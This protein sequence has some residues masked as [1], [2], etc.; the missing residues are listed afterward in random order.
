MRGTTTIWRALAQARRDRLSESGEAAPISESPAATRRALLAGIAATGAIG[1]AGALAALPRGGPAFTG[2]RVAI[3]G[4]GM[5]GLSALHRL[6]GE[7]IDARLYEASRRIGGRIH[8]QRGEGG[9]PTFEVG[10]QLVNTDHGD[11]H[12]LLREFGIALI[13]RKA[14]THKT[15]VIANGKPL[16][17]D[18]LVAGLG[19]IAAQIGADA[20]RLDADYAGQA[21]RIDRLSIAQYLDLHADLMPEPW[22]RRLLEATSRS[23]YG[24]EPE[25]ASALGLVF[26]LPTVEG[27][28]VDVLGGADER[29]L[30]E[31]GSDTL[32]R[33]LAARHANRI[34]TGRRLVRIERDGGAMRLRFADG[35]SARA[36]RVIVALPAGIAGRIAYDVPIPPIWHR[37]HKE[38]ALGTNEK[39]QVATTAR[40]G[41]QACGTGGEVWQT[42]A[43]GGW[44]QGWD[45]SVH[46]AS[47]VS[48]V[49][50]WY[51]G[52]D[53][54][55]ARTKP[56]RDQAASFAGAVAR[57]MP[58][59]SPGSRVVRRTA[60]HRDPL[61][62]GGYVNYAPGVLTRYAK[63]LWIEGAGH[64][65]V[66]SGRIQ[67]AGEHLSDAFPG[68]MNGAAQTGRMAAEA[69]IGEG[70]AAAA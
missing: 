28:R 45:G 55:L 46:G 51:L 50:T 34:E 58:E 20:D 42:D 44:S 63:L 41:A 35:D 52:G 68:Y 3:V 10:G 49:W 6:T 9:D 37:F 65:R 67:F 56:P 25:A 18:R 70:R 69:L 16:S 60:W 61:I 1:T 22:V 31:G 19:P 62:G 8:T 15:L 13:D 43:G 23:E 11:M 30:I 39:V 54:A 12:A 5:A 33:A 24:A 4:G 38:I 2:G 17:Q 47:G 48:P 59:L 26:N 21:P 53:E 32:P 66:D 14:G 7:G 40:P 57:S 64:S 27:R 29:Y 36:D